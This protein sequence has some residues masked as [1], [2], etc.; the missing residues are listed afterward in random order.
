[1]GV[2]VDIVLVLGAFGA[3]LVAFYKLIGTKDAQGSA[4]RE[5]D[6]EERKELTEAIKVMAESSQHVASATEKAA[7]EAK[8]RNG[9]LG[10]QNIQIANLV[11]KQNKDVVSIRDTNRKIANILSNSAIIAAEDR[12]LLLGHEQHIDTQVVEHQEIINKEQ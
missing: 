3:M 9:H 8:E 7:R 2:N 6:R 10:E 11:T 12:E 1:M 4:D 5:A